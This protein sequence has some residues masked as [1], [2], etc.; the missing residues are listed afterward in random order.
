[1]TQMQP[2]ITPLHPT[3]SVSTQVKSEPLGLNASLNAYN[4]FPIDKQIT[5]HYKCFGYL[6]FET[7]NGGHRL[8]KV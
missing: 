7:K 6:N 5:E 4:Y 3:T 1:M 2:V 8:D